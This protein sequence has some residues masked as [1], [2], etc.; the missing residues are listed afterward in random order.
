MA[1]PITGGRTADDVRQPRLD[2]IDAAGRR[3]AQ[4]PTAH[5]L[6]AWQAARR[7][8]VTPQC[9]T[10]W[11]RNG[12]LAP[13][14]RKVD[15]RNPK[16]T[17]LITGQQLAEFEARA[18]LVPRPQRVLPKLAPPSPAEPLTQRECLRIIHVLRWPPLGSVPCPD[19]DGTDHY[20][21]P[22][23]R[24]AVLICAACERKFSQLHSTLFHGTS[25]PLPYWFHIVYHTDPRR[26]RFGFGVALARR[27][28]LAMSTTHRLIRMIRRARRDPTHGPFLCALSKRLDALAARTNAIDPTIYDRQPRG[29]VQRSAAELPGA[30]GDD[31][32]LGWYLSRIL[33]SD[34]SRFSPGSS[35]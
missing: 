5:T 13:T 22:G 11:I 30:P 14:G 2:G 6:S 35:P 33:W 34:P 31:P 1:E 15:P 28:D 9:V 10:G 24:H 32:I 7:L 23:R 17:Y 25:L 19:C 12:H 21:E 20:P 4:Y 8:G 27:L 3:K 16:S 29:R 18:K 26:Y